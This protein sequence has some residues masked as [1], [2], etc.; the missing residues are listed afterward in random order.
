MDWASRDKNTETCTF[1]ITIAALLL[2]FG[3]MQIML[4]NVIMEDLHFISLSVW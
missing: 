1:E 2:M 4:K 3:A